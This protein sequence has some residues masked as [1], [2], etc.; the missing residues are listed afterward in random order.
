MSPTTGEQEESQLW[1]C[2]RR[3]VGRR[4]E[5]DRIADDQEVYVLDANG[6][7]VACICSAITSRN[8]SM[9]S[10]IFIEVSE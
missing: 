8:R 2:A 5:T 4:V 3:Q 10:M 7:A 6:R 9:A 1:V